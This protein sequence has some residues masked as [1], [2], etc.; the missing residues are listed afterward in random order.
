MWLL[1]FPVNMAWAFATGNIRDVRTLN[2]L[3]LHG[4]P[5]FFP[6]R[7]AAV[8]A[9]YY[10]GL[11]VDRRGKVTSTGEPPPHPNVVFTNKWGLNG[12]GATPTTLGEGKIAPLV[13]TR[14]QL[15]RAKTNKATGYIWMRAIDFLALTTTTDEVNWLQ[16]VAGRPVED[17][18]FYN[19]LALDGEITVMP[20]LEVNADLNEK[21]P[22]GQVVG[23]EGRHRAAAVLYAGGPEAV[24]AVAILLRDADYGLWYYTSDEN[25]N[26][27]FTTLEDI[28]RTLY[29]QQFWIRGV[30]YGRSRPVHLTREAFDGAE[31]FWP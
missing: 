13:V 12:L 28:P 2:P 22:I 23:H 6:S 26:K 25:W 27:L 10:R 31:E 3:N 4:F 30:N 17:I 7:E 15:A 1:Y 16:S 11:K 29:P 8:E 20:L 18:N 14:E 24:L 9:A 21:G 5:K 19:R